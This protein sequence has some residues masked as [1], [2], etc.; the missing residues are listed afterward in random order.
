VTEENN[1]SEDAF[2]PI[3]GCCLLRIDFDSF[4]GPDVVCEG[5]PEVVLESIMGETFNDVKPVEGA[6]GASDASVVWLD[7][8]VSLDAIL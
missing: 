6:G 5:Y 3:T 4:A 2:R 7:P 1:F 8:V